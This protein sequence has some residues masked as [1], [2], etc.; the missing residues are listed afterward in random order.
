MTETR[1]RFDKQIE[2]FKNNNN[3]ILY[4]FIRKGSGLEVI[5]IYE[6]ELDVKYVLDE[7]ELKIEKI[8]KKRGIQETLIGTVRLK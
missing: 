7:S 4:A 5:E 3:K 1:K 8:N 2:I 6:H